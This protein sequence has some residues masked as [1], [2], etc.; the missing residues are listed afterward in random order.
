M[1]FVLLE[2]H[3]LIKHNILLVLFAMLLII[4]VSDDNVNFK[5]LL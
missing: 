2:T 4:K 5:M 3:F 1:L